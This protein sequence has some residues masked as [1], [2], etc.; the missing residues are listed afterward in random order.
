MKGPKM[1]DENPAL[2]AARDHLDEIESKIEEKVKY[3]LRLEKQIEALERKHTQA[4]KAFFV[5]K[6]GL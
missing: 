2:T 6:A 1:K 4:L 5:I 3:K